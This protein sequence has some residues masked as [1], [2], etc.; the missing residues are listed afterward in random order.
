MAISD[1]M[2]G[3]RNKAA[4]V[5]KDSLRIQ[6][7]QAD[8]ELNNR[9]IDRYSVCIDKCGSG[10]K[11]CPECH[12]VLAVKVFSSSECPLGYWEDGKDK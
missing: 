10:V 1:I 9:A 4:L 5:I 3:L 8:V 7:T 12:C 6:Y 11:V 2:N